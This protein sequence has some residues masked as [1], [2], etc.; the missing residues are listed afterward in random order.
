VQIKAH[1]LL[2]NKILRVAYINK[3]MRMSKNR[4]RD[5]FYLRLDPSIYQEY[6]RIQRRTAVITCHGISV[7]FLLIGILNMIFSQM[8]GVVKNKLIFAIVFTLFA[9]VYTVLS[10]LSRRK[11]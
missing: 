7:I 1:N 2:I 11:P 5:F 6:V 3:I 9:I 8:K 4:C 10:I